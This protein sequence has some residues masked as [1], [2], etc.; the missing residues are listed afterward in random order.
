[1]TY[2]SFLQSSTEF[3]VGCKWD[4]VPSWPSDEDACSICSHLHISENL[5]S[6]H[7]QTLEHSPCKCNRLYLS[8]QLKDWG[9]ENTVA[10]GLRL[11]FLTAHRL[12][13]PHHCT[14]ISAQKVRR[15][16]NNMMACTSTEEEEE[17][18]KDNSFFLY[19]GLIKVKHHGITCVPRWSDLKRNSV[20]VSD[21]SSASQL[22]R[23]TRRSIRVWLISCYLI[24]VIWWKVFKG[25]PKLYVTFKGR[26]CLFIFKHFNFI[27]IEP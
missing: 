18:E 19:F 13:L 25:L 16:T 4:I 11:F 3:D 5:R 17:G 23:K 7:H 9:A 26:V 12:D 27:W 2:L 6:W 21:H 8:S 24:K 20:G 14:Y 1:M 10:L 22:R 15:Y